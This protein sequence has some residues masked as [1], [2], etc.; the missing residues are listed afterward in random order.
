VTRACWSVEPGFERQSGSVSFEPA[1]FAP[2]VVLE[3]SPRPEEALLRQMVAPARCSKAPGL[4]SKSE[5]LA[6][7]P[8]HPSRMLVTARS[9]QEA[10]NA[11]L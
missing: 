2:A 3:R 6:T 8:P 7:R 5:A 1:A 11:R 10:Q 4:Y 9:Y